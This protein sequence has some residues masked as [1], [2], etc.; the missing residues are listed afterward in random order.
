MRRALAALVLAAVDRFLH[1]RR[2]VL[3]AHR[4]PV[5]AER[6]PD[7]TIAPTRNRRSQGDR[8]RIFG[9]TQVAAD[10]VITGQVV[11][12]MGSVRTFT[13]SGNA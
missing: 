2:E 12:V 6:R 13:C 1:V 10:E 3:N 5:E 7:T 9:D 8:V 4:Q 11:A